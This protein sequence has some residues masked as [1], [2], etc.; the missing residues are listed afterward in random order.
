MGRSLSALSLLL[1]CVAGVAPGIA[2]AAVPPEVPQY[3][4]S[5]IFLPFEFAAP[6]GDSYGGDVL[7]AGG[8]DCL[9][10]GRLFDLRQSA[11]P[12]TTKPADTNLERFWE[13]LR[14]SAG[15]LYA[16]G[17]ANTTVFTVEPYE[18]S[19]AGRTAAI[20]AANGY[21]QNGWG[22]GSEI[23]YGQTSDGW[24][25]TVTQGWIQRMLNIA[26]GQGRNPRHDLVLFQGC[27]SFT[28]ALSFVNRQGMTRAFA[29]QT[30]LVN[31]STF[32]NPSYFNQISS[33]ILN[34]MS[35]VRN[36][37]FGYYGN[38]PFVGTLIQAN[39]VSPILFAPQTG[40][41]ADP[42]YP[43]NAL[44]IRLYNAPRIVLSDVDQDSDFNGSYNRELYRYNPYPAYPYGSGTMPYPGS[45]AVSGQI[46][47]SSGPL[48][49]NL[50]FSEPMDVSSFTA[51]LRYADGST[52]AVS[53]SW[54][55]FEVA[56]DSWSATTS[57][58]NGVIRLEVFGRKV[59]CGSGQDTTVM[60]LD[61][62]G[63]GT[64][65]PGTYDTSVGFTTSGPSLSV[66]GG[67]PA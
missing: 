59:V 31:I 10:Y 9:E 18:D 26:R 5:E 11:P 25:V 27:H 21:V 35:G 37:A 12:S 46:S 43:P 64:G 44:Q 61:L 34:N 4:K 56:N 14:S 20:N 22:Y 17:H 57:I 47:N 49:I 51:R 38:I 48:R 62:D 1:A 58:S 39:A 23:S 54:G 6:V 3:R 29:G 63:D 65:V 30:N 40:F 24:T 55:T 50:I 66:E 33:A 15:I 28:S 7:S 53:G 60:Y 52:Q 16:V 13:I 41:F 19:M 2:T 45:A 36:D 42:N 8:P 67:L 32:A